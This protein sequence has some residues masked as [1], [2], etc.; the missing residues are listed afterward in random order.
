MLI[1]DIE[2]SNKPSKRT[3][4][5]TNTPPT[6]TKAN[7]NKSPP[8]RAKANEPCNARVKTVNNHNNHNKT[9]QTK[10]KTKSFPWTN[11]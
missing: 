6:P 5:N 3:T 9:N 4:K 2:K 1:Y 11:A 7:N 8:N 10:T